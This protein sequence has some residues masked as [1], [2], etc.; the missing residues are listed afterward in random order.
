MKS[1]Y[2][3]TKLAITNDIDVEYSLTGKNR[4]N[5]HTGFFEWGI[6]V[7]KYTSGIKEETEE[8]DN[9][10]PDYNKVSKLLDALIRNKVTPVS[11]RDVL[12]N[13]ID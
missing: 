13:L 11:V 12:E 5:N 2:Y 3:K 1:V 10:S 8:I 4:L 6:C 7:T 9:I